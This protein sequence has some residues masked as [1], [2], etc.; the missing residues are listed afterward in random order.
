MKYIYFVIFLSNKYIQVSC[1][2]SL[3]NNGIG[4]LYM[5]LVFNENKTMNNN[6]INFLLESIIKILNINP[7]FNYNTILII[8]LIFITILN[9]Y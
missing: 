4:L 8:L 9:Y 1:E 5:A 2:K 6:I 3:L 7:Q